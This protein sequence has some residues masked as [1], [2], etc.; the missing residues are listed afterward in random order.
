MQNR[1]NALPAADGPSASITARALGSLRRDSD[2]YLDGLN[3]EQR[4][5]VET[6][7]G[8]ILVLAGAGTGKTRVLTTRIAHLI[9]TGRARPFDILAVTFTNKAAREMKLRIGSLIGPAGEG[10]PWLGTFHAIGT[11]ILRRHA[12]LVG[13]KS[14][15]TIL[16]TDDQLRLMKQ[17]LA[18]QNIDEKRWPARSLAH[19]IDGWKNRG[20]SPEQVPPGEATSF[21]FGKGGALY[22]A[23]QARLA[24]LNAVDFGDLLLLCLKLWRENKDVLE[25]YQDRFRYILVDEYQDT[26]VAQYLWLRLLAQKRKNVACVGDDDQSIYGWR[27]AE[28]DNILRFEHD[29]PGAT[30]VR[31]ERNY[32]STGHILAAASGLIAKNESRLGK[33]LRTEDEPG[34]PV[35][36]TGAWD[37]EEEARLLAEAIE[38]LQVKKHPLSEIAV[39]V[40][41]SAQM[42]EIEDRF[43][44]LG[45]P[46]RVIGGPRFYERAEIRDALAY[47]RITMNGSDDLAFERI[48]NTPKRGLGDATLQQLHTYGRAERVPLLTAA[49]R[50]CETDELK[51]RVRQTLRAL[52]E[53][54]SRWA[55]LVETQP[56]SEVAQTILEESGYTEMWQ[57]DRSADAAG[58]LENLKEFV[59]SMEEFPDMAA[60][61][62]H[63]SLVMEASEAEG[64]ER[65]SLMTL[66]A[67]KGLEF[68]TVFLPGWEDGLFPNQR[69]LDESGRAGLEEERRLAH[70]GLTRARKRAK[71]SFAVNRRIHGLWS[72]T[73]PSRFIDELPPASVDVV[74]APAHY[75]AGASR[76]DRNPQPF[77]SSYGTPGWQR[78]QANTG[79][80][81]FGAAPGRRGTP[82]S[83]PRQIEGELIAKSTGSP[84][85]FAVEQRVFHTKF[86]PGTVAGVDGNKLTV[87]FDKAGRKMVLDSFVQAG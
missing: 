64:A 60:F 83:G 46:Y 59:R 77:G 9:A 63:V 65:V 70:V 12:E 50:L 18:D 1:P 31:L 80:R 34:E 74:E 53:S 30:V 6:T 67:A 7:E 15:F 66:H 75:A 19:T 61:L 25:N 51:P 41:I 57:K 20:L 81:G 8:P 11:K 29:F 48:V 36:V 2:V 17:V 56:H 54:F 13:L 85:A 71:L 84:S 39:L 10:M 72:S 16:G 73:I 69:A 5:A 24:T 76:F 78:A 55:R 28:V 87:D 14:D 3:P 62:E 79:G 27:G 4:L 44:Q 68:D 23:Y 37:S 49:R 38:S 35:T 58:R 21:A 26:N 40:R 33:T 22:T 42:R 47:L 52:T 86:G 45:L 32:R 43:V 82:S